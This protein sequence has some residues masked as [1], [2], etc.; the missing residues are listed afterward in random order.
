VRWCYNAVTIVAVK[1][2]GYFVVVGSLAV[3]A[4]YFIGCQC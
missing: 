2:P 4:A 1:R 3:V